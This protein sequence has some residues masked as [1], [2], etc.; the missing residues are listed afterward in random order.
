MLEVI[1]PESE[2]ISKL[3]AGVESYRPLK[4]AVGDT[5]TPVDVFS[6]PQLSEV[7]NHCFWASTQTEEGRTVT[8]SVCICS[9]A[10]T[11]RVFRQAVPLSV[12]ALVEL[13]I[14]SP[15]SALAVRLGADGPEVWGFLDATGDPSPPQLRIGG[16]GL[17]VARNHDGVLAV[18]ERGEVHLPTITVR[19]S[20]LVAKCL[21][22][23]QPFPDR[24]R[25]GVALHR[26]V[27]SIQNQGHGGALV[28]VPN[29]ANNWQNNL[30][31]AYEFDESSSRE[32]RNRMSQLQ[33]AVVRLKES[34]SQAMTGTEVAFSRR[35]PQIMVN[36]NRA[37]LDSLLDSVG[38]LSAIDGAIVLREDLTVLGFG[39]KL[40]A[41][42]GSF[43]VLTVDGLTAFKKRVPHTDLGGMRHQ[44]A[45]CFVQEN[46]DVMIV[47]ASQDGRLS[48][49]VWEE[50]GHQ[51]VAFRR[52]E[53]LAV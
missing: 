44:S 41:T 35:N 52:L 8:G 36:A 32:I 12:K 9:S 39:A 20:E 23:A 48:L 27:R 7:V 42:P 49:F 34:Q 24:L 5:G 46:H 45:A 15:G 47:V 33:D 29:E 38:Q 53:H 19:I 10:S 25:S 26:V 40:H 28:V 21:N 22:A 37:L 18:L 11:S 14:A 16:T 31:F 43:E 2:F 13:F 6:G 3:K 4:E 17:I 1:G 51:V 30:K 50:E